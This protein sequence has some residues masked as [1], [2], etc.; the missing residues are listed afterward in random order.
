MSNE[1]SVRVIAV[2]LLAMTALAPVAGAT[3]VE[4]GDGTVERVDTDAVTATATTTTTVTQTAP[5]DPE[6][7]VQ[8]WED[9]YWYNE[10]LPEV[11]PSDGYTDAEIDKVRARAMAR[12]EV[13]RDVEFAV[14]PPVEVISRER[15]QENVAERFRNA[16]VSASARLHQNV[17]FEALFMVGEDDSYFAAQERLRGGSV[18]G[19]YAYGGEREGDIVLVSEDTAT[20]KIDEQTLAQE[21][22]HS[23][24]DQQFK[25]TGDYDVRTEEDSRRVT[26]IVEGDG[27]YV[28]YLY[29]R[30]CGVEWQCFQPETAGGGG[31][32]RPN[33]GL[34]VYGLPQYTE[35][36]AWVASVHERG[37]WAAVNDLYENPPESTEQ[38]IHPEKYLQDAPTE[39]TV[40]DRSTDAWTILDLG[41]G[42]TNYAEFGEAGLYTM[43]WYS[44][45]AVPNG[46]LFTGRELD[47]YDYDHPASAGW[48]GD[49]LYPYVNETSAETNETGYVWQTAWD[50]PADAEEFGDA[51]TQILTSFGDT[52]DGRA[53]TYRVTA[54]RFA[55]AFYVNVSGATVTIVNAPT[56]E[57]LS[58][59]RSGAAPETTV[60]TTPTATATA[61]P[62]TQ[63][64][65]ATAE[66]TAEPTS[67]T[68]D[69]ETEAEPQPG[70][71]L[72]VAVLAVVGAALLLRRRR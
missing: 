16:N 67:V 19:Y 48:D 9:G 71:G 29:D 15:Y 17:K 35:G 68:A 57:D 72:V 58:A 18:L 70:F 24:Q 54:S 46:D 13:I 63:T 43:L 59:V 22:F 51:Y 41:N 60:T 62:A 44:S 55:D 11:D 21:L 69:T 30:R 37:G 56:V 14:T 28:D 26:A 23:L 45:P 66:T 2:A 36:P 39:V 50:S 34:L 32:P 6:T 33:L 5:E 27:N 40:A 38:Y 65:T 64:A 8:G 3:V 47:A 7:D 20:P 25:I 61:T 1:T 52:V 42:S 12:I 4:A 53:D 31:G 10:S 49:K